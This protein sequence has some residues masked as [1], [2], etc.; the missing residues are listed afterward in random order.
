MGRESASLARA[1]ACERRDQEVVVATLRALLRAGDRA[2]ASEILQR[3]VVRLGGR[4]V[5][6]D[7]AGP[8]AIPADVSLG[9]GTPQV[10][11]AGGD[12]EDRRRLAAHVALLLED[13]SWSATRSD[14]LIHEFERASVDSLTGVAARGEIGLRLG[15]ATPGDVVCVLD[16]D[17]FKALNDRRGHSAGDA[18]LRE[19]GRLLTSC[20][21]D[22][23]FV[24][25]LGGDEFLVLLPSTPVGVALERMERVQ[26]EWRG[27]SGEVSVSIGV[28]A[29]GPDGGT[30]AIE[31]A[32]RALYQAKQAGRQAIVLAPHSRDRHHH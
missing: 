25:R 14:M 18:A 32:D 3:T 5:P 11:V 1:A 16:L 29:V 31:A 4:V 28:A 2:E 26:R 10:V 6:A 24:G 23:D 13:A 27:S 22:G 20:I 17:H 21:R 12:G 15:Y 30:E 19:M 7:E 9:N 8:D